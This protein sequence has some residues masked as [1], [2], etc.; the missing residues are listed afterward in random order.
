LTYG[1]LISYVQKTALEICQNDKLQR[2]L[3]KEK[4]QSRKE[5]GTF[6]EQFGILGCSTKKTRKVVKQ[7]QFPSSRPR[8]NRPKFRKS[9]KPFQSKESKT[10]SKPPTTKSII[11]YNCRK[12]GHTSKYYRLKR[13]L[14]NLNLE[15]ELE[16]KI[17]NLLVETSEEESDTSKSRID[18]I[19]NLFSKN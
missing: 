2:Q 19:L 12:P 11:C 15:P 14:S 10:Q 5:L 17:N 7:E 1:Q 13:K 18:M 16:E 6:C 4:S 3:A 8:N 9:R